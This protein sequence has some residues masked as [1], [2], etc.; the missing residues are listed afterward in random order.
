MEADPCSDIKDSRRD[1]LG[2]IDD[3]V[4]SIVNG[5]S[6]KGKRGSE[7]RDLESFSESFESDLFL[8]IRGIAYRLKLFGGKMKGGYENIQTEID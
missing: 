8:F 5:L 2:A 6:G 4:K 7:V 3:V 1:V